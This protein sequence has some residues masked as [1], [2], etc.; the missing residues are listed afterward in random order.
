MLGHHE[1]IIEINVMFLPNITT[2]KEEIEVL[3]NEEITVKCS[4]IGNPVPIL[5]WKN[6]LKGD[7][8]RNLGLEFF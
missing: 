5:T 1:A 2:S 6:E 7:R 4:A 3:A 8:K